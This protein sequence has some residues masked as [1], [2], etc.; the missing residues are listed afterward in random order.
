LLCGAATQTCTEPRA[1]SANRT[2]VLIAMLD[3]RAEKG[4]GSE[5]L[6]VGDLDAV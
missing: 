2:T 1:T 6:A 5:R 3:F 4:A